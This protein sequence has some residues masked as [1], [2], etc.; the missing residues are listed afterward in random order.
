[1]PEV[2]P[3]NASRHCR[4]E[5]HESTARISELVAAIKD[6]THMDRAAVEDVDV[7]DGLDSTLTMLKYRIK[8]EPVKVERIYDQTARA[9]E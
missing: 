3:P 5:L 4:C 1:M 9:N 6:Y 7:H 2:L 8:H